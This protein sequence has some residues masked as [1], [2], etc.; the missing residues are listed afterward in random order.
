M[1]AREIELGDVRAEIRP[2]PIE[3]RV[4]FLHVL[5][6]VAGIKCDARVV[7]RRMLEDLLRE[8]HCVG[9]ALDSHAVH[10]EVDLHVHVDFALRHLACRGE[11]T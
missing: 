2:E 4:L 3:V 7:E 8:R 10:P 6:H 1:H 5:T 9:R 11:L